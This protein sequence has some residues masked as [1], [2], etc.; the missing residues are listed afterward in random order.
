MAASGKPPEP[1]LDATLTFDPAGDQMILFGGDSGHDYPSLMGD[2]WSLDL[3][4]APLWAPIVARGTPAAPR[5]GHGVVYDP[6]RD[7]LLI[8]GGRLAPEA[9]FELSLRPAPA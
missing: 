7:R 6:S 9:L 4:G 3:G 1:R 2:L 8:Y 5:A